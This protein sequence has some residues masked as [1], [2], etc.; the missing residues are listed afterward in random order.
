MGP[1]CSM[2]GSWLLSSVRML[3][4]DTCGEG[5]VGV[6]GS[7]GNPSTSSG[8]GNRRNVTRKMKGAT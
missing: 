3:R 7:S 2:L 1:M 8:F 6:S 4:F 5:R